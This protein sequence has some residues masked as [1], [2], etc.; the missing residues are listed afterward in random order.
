MLTAE[1]LAQFKKKLLAEK[2]KLETELSQI[3]DKNLDSDKN[4]T[5][6][7]E[8]LGD[9]L[10]DNVEEYR[11]HEL[12]L[13]LEK[14][15]GQALVDVNDALE[16][17]TKGTYGICEGTGKPISLARLEAYPAARY[18]VEYADKE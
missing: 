5:A 17:I 2:I 16:R 6:R 11:Q 15:L 1:Q 4:Y 10:E 3:A 14:N 12:N 18:S 13:S 8:D 9:E 7:Y